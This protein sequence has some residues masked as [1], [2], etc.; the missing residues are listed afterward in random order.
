MRDNDLIAAM[1]AAVGE[2]ARWTEVL[3]AIKLRL[4][5][6][7]AVFQRLVAD[8]NDLIP[9][10]SLRDT[11][12]TE[13]ASRHD[14]WAN[15][16]HNPRFRRDTEPRGM[17]EIDS[18]Q[19]NAFLSEGDREALRHGLSTCGLG[20][21]FWLG[22][23]IAPGEH[24]TMIFH[25]HVGDGRDMTQA[26]LTFLS[27]LLPHFRQ[28][29]R[30]LT[31][32][33]GYEA[34]LSVAEA[35]MDS[36]SL[37]LLACDTNLGV[38]W[39]NRAAESLVASLPQLGFSGGSL[40]FR[41]AEAGAAV[42]AAID[43]RCGDTCRIPGNDAAEVLHVRVLRRDAADQRRWGRNLALVA[44]CSP[45]TAPRIDAAEVADLFGLTMAEATLTTHL[46]GGMTVK[47]F[48]AYR[49]IAEGTARMQLK[50]ALAKA[51]V[52]RQADLVRQVC[53]SLARL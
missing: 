22:C 35:F 37:A 4:G 11:W 14:A 7:S 49:G 12:S 36:T 34:R 39:M 27:H 9:V 52:G 41:R 40:H 1:Y 18:D 38:H 8:K 44:L 42:R 28:V 45:G 33:A 16:P 24:T 51:G 21:G 26:D 17:L 25:R 43:G 10:I 23:R 31:C 13:E 19:R 47:D 3:D 5:V 30:L 2:D 6:A 20:P 48:A 29:S 32:I 15:S 46:V 50:S 53:Q